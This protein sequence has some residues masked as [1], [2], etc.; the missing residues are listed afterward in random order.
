MRD[1]AVSCGSDGADVSGQSEQCGCKLTDWL[2]AFYWERG[3]PRPQM[4]A[5]REQRVRYD[6]GRKNLILSLGHLAGEGARA[7]SEEVE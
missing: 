4:S 2:I 6:R 7:P 1:I 5:Q 3:R